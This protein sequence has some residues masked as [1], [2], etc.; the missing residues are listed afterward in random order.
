MANGKIERV[1]L[2]RDMQRKL[3]DMVLEQKTAI[4]DDKWTMI[5]FAAHA[6]KK[7]GRPV[8]A[9]N[10]RTAAKIMG[11]VFHKHQGRGAVALKDM[12]QVK[13]AL[14]ITALELRRCMGELGFTTTSE[15][16][17]LCDEM[18]DNGTE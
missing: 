13:A 5:S 17:L 6:E 9:C 12:R 15:F 18:D 14:R 11:V 1:C 8:T 7:L 2:T 10:V 4:E 16:N 3:E